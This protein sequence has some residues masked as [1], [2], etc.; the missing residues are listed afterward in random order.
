MQ[1][2]MLDAAPDA[3]LISWLYMPQPQR[4]NTGDSYSLADWVYE[5]PS[6]T[7]E[8]V[9]LQF[10][11]ESGI[12]R[13]EF[14]KLLV[15]GD[16]WISN[17]GPSSRF[18]KVAETAVKSKT[19][20]SAKIQTGCSHEVA[21]VPYVPVPSLLYKKFSEMHRMGVSHTMLCWYFGNYPGMENKVA[22][23]LTFEPFPGTEDEFLKRLASIYWRKNDA[24]R[25]VEAWKH[26]SRGYSN[27]PLTNLFQYYG[28]MHDGPVWPLH[29]KPQDSPLSPTWQIGSSTTLQPWPPSGD[30]IGECLGDILTLA[31]V[32]ELAGKMCRS[33]D[34]GLSL[35]EGMEAGY[36]MEPDRI[37]DIGV[38]KALGIQFRSGYNILHF[39][40]LREKMFRMEG[41]ERL[42][43]LNQMNRIV[44]EEIELDKKLLYLCRNDS[45]LGFHSEAEGYK[46]FPEK[47]R[48][49][50]NQLQ[51]LLDNDFPET[52]KLIRSGADLYPEYTGKK[53]QGPC[54]DCIRVKGTDWQ[55]KGSVKDM[56]LNW[57]NIKNKGQGSESK[58]A[59]CYDDTAV[60]IVVSCLPNEAAVSNIN[61]RIEPFRLWPCHRFV[62]DR[63]NNRTVGN[64]GQIRVI[65]ES[66][67]NY[68]IAEIPFARMGKNIN[69]P[70]PVRMNLRIYRQG[71]APYSWLPEHP[72]TSRLIL[73]SDNPEDLGWVLFR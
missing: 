20:V 14:G 21:S 55:E 43:L 65:S 72:V 3:E 42:K 2:G 46:Y 12:T 34:R 70:G 28:P 19:P 40:L 16:Y 47:I 63:G 59:A 1:K 60:Y 68:S 32:T 11:F 18:E 25:M 64:Y 56:N 54:V 8:G 7:P 24:G 61:V 41:K 36:M 31:E 6:H 23:E 44:R 9:V 71:E 35:L 5:I 4:Y 53:P 51:G 22:S 38:A 45:R 66:G 10:N 73:G 17:P 39:Y 33:W 48:W 15:G 30:R 49:R 58:W 62:F 27:Y 50:M 57:Q 52:E 67:V 37:M 29:L 13:T 69:E 26:F